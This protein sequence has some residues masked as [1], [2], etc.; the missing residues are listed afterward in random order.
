MVFEI[1]CD[2]FRPPTDYLGGSKFTNCVLVKMVIF[3]WDI[4]IMTPMTI[5]RH[6]TMADDAK[7]QISVQVQITQKGQ[8]APKK[9]AYDVIKEH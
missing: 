5:F 7:P 4:G 1:Q 3:I 2:V 8:K 9:R 6:I